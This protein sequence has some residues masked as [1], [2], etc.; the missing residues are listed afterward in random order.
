MS[1]FEALKFQVVSTPNLIF[2]QIVGRLRIKKR[3]LCRKCKRTCHNASRHAGVTEVELAGASKR[4]GGT[5]GMYARFVEDTVRRRLIT[6]AR[7]SSVS[8]RAL[9]SRRVVSATGTPTP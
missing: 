7:P 2:L 4:M 6:F 1:D 5:T 3:L 8:N 9:G